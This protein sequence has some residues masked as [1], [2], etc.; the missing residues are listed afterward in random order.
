MKGI[1]KRWYVIFALLLTG[2]H[3]FGQFM[4]QRVFAGLGYGLDYGGFGGKIEYVTAKNIGVFAGLGYNHISAGWNAGATLKI[5][6][7]KTISV[8]PMV[9]YGYNG[10]VSKIK[11]APEYEMI[12][13]G[14]T[15][16]FN[17]DI[18]LGRKSK[19]S[20]GLFVPFRSRKFRDNYQAMK[21][22][23]AVHITNELVPVSF[24]VGYSYKFYS[25]Y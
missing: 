11:N 5:L 12:S 3:I 10:G 8:N 4:E 2:S 19:F 23:P 6:P 22:D 9:F 20:V 18:M 13:L 24:S 25:K 1:S 16:G 17:M 21:N 14:A 15:A 7:N